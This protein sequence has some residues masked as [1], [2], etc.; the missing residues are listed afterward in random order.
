VI[1]DAKIEPQYSNDYAGSCFS[2]LLDQEYQR[3][4]SQYAGKWR[5][6]HRRAGGSR[7]L[8]RAHGQSGEHL[9]AH[10]LDRSHGLVCRH[11][12]DSGP[13]LIVS[14]QL[15]L[16]TALRAGHAAE[17]KACA[18][19]NPG[20]EIAARLSDAGLAHARVG[21]A[22]VRNIGARRCRRSTSMR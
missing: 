17:I 14:N 10:E 21:I 12:G 13:W 6:A 11:D 20:P 19:M 18:G 22:G 16:H 3:R 5:R 1:R 7:G 9:L 15:F 4:Y 2:A 8:R